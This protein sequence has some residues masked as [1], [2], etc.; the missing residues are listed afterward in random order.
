MKKVLVLCTG[1]SCRSQIAE[2]YLRTF[3]GDKAEIY[4][5]GVETHGVNPRAI[6]TMLEDGIDLSKHTSNN[7]EEYFNIDFDFVITVCDNAKERCPY[8]PTRALMF[9]QNFPDPAKAIGTETE[10]LA[11]FRSVREMI[12]TFSLRFVSDHL[13]E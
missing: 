6:A 5:A 1:N 3:A 9:H 12:K 8:F 7:V 2:A 13:T 11:Q 4:S 10:I